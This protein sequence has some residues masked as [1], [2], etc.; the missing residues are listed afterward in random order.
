MPPIV[1]VSVANMLQGTKPE[2]I[3]DHFKAL[4]GESCMPTVG[5]IVAYEKRREGK[6]SQ[7]R[8]SATVA[9]HGSGDW[10]NK[11]HKSKLCPSIKEVGYTKI[12]VESTF[13]GVTYLKEIPQHDFE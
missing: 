4:L 7:L 6:R 2:D 9:F 13:A 10:R 12:T 11:L 8:L 3:S 5:P 1:N